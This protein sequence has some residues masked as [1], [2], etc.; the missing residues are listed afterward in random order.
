MSDFRGD[1]HIVG[2][3]VKVNGRKV[4]I[5]AVISEDAWPL[6]GRVDAWV[7]EKRPAAVSSDFVVARSAAAAGL[8]APSRRLREPVGA[9][10]SLVFLA[11]LFAPPTAVFARG[12]AGIR[13]WAFLLAKGA[14]ILLPIYSVE[15]FAF[16]STS[17]LMMILILLMFPTIVLSFRWAWADQRRRC[18]VCLRRL[19]DPVQFG[20]ASHTFLDW[21]GME[22]MCNQGHGVLRVPEMATSCSGEQEW[23][24]LDELCWR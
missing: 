11:C 4:P 1:R 16:Q 5:A 9:L 13:V 20:K 15:S 24:N 7:L 17:P 2:R 8:A 12:R 18:P 6:D 22:L 23:V 10:I 3:V 14:L 19:S 21:Y